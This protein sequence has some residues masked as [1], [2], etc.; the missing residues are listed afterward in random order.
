MRI[1]LRGLAIESLISVFF[2]GCGGAI[3]PLSITTTSLA[4]GEVGTAYSATLAASGGRGP[5]NWRILSSGSAL[6][7]GLS[8]STAGVISGTPT[9]AA[10]NKIAFQVAD[11]ESTPRTATAS[12]TLTTDAPPLPPPPPATLQITTTS[13]NAGTLGVAY[14]ATLAATGGT[15]PY[16]W[17][18]GSIPL[19]PGL[20][21]NASSGA[22]SGTPTALGSYF[23]SFSVSDSAKHTVS[24]QALNIIVNPTLGSIPNGTYSFSFG[25]TVTQGLV[26]LAIDGSFTL[27]NGTTELV[28]PV[29]ILGFIVSFALSRM[30]DPTLTSSHFLR[31]PKQN[32]AVSVRRLAEALSQLV[33]IP[34]AFT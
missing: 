33:K 12:L 16:T 19:P 14:S 26:G 28:L 18:V 31:K 17:S 2:V 23:P 27:S 5:Y 24:T 21:I 32:L 22:I 7:A 10:S 6:P 8:L 11:S 15:P 20:T 30:C 1:G 29:H 25:G 3:A 13:L 4:A 34:C 9:A